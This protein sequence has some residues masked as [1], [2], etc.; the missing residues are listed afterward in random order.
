MFMKDG[1]F[2]FFKLL[3]VALLLLVSSSCL[4]LSHL[5]IARLYM[6]LP[7]TLVNLPLQI[8]HFVVY[9]EVNIDVPWLSR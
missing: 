9:I 6:K 4:Y 5:R 1:V 3:N 2:S 7:L 8:I